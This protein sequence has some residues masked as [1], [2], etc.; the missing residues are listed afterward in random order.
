MDVLWVGYHRHY[1]Y[2]YLKILHS[3]QGQYRTMNFLDWWCLLIEHFHQIRLFIHFFFSPLWWC[4]RNEFDWR[5]CGNTYMWINVS[6]YRFKACY[7]IH[8]ISSHSILDFN[9]FWWLILLYFIGY[10]SFVRLSLDVCSCVNFGWLC[11]FNWF[12][13]GIN[14][15]VFPAHLGF[16]ELTE[17]SEPFVFFLALLFLHNFPTVQLAFVLD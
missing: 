4:R 10:V 7:D 2:F 1:Q 12:G 15:Y 11:S 3:K 16:R 9:L 13:V 5:N 6:A 14:F 17:T 8:C